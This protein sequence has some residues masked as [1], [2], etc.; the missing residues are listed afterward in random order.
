MRMSMEKMSMKGSVKVKFDFGWTLSALVIVF[1]LVTSIARVSFTWT[2]QERATEICR[3]NTLNA[4]KEI[5]EITGNNSRFTDKDYF[6]AC[7]GEYVKPDMEVIMDVNSWRYS[8]IYP[9]LRV[10]NPK[11]FR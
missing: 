5:S 3:L 1:V 10:S 8:D 4:A 2:V 9:N 7:V 6:D 11:E